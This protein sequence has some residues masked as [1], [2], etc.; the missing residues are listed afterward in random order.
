MQLTDKQIDDLIYRL[1]SALFI[2]RSKLRAY[3]LQPR[4]VVREWFREVAD[5][6]A[7]QLA[8]LPN[9]PAFLKQQAE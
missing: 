8:E 9:L 2:P 1:D 3:A 7:G 4:G 5:K 6:S